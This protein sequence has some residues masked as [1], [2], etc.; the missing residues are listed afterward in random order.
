MI[1]ENTDRVYSSVKE[2]LNHAKS[3]ENKSLLDIYGSKSI[4]AFVEGNKGEF[5][6][7]V[8]RLHYGIMN[9]NKSMPDIPNLKIEIKTSPL[10]MVYKGTKI[11]P[12]QRTTLSMIDYD[13]IIEENFETSF[14]LKKNEKILLNLY[15]LGPEKIHEQRFLFIDLLEPSKDDLKVIKEDW[16]IIKKKVR[17]K[18]ADSLSQSDT[19]YLCAATKGG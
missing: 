6:Q 18:N 17:S 2:L 19:T 15:L 7:L 16:E 10:K 13:Q 9:N 14:F 11:S 5:G 1:K 8:E 3:L 12:D 4:Q